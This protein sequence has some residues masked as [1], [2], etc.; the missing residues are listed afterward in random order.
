MNWKRQIMALSLSDKNCLTY[1]SEMI[2]IWTNAVDE[3]KELA[4]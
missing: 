4:G 2:V 1:K 3:D